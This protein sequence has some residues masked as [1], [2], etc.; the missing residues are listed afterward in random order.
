MKILLVNKFHYLKGGSEKYYFELAEL[1]KEHGHIVAFFSMKND[2]NIKTGDKEYFVDE[3]DL[4]T[5][6]KFKALD[7][8]YSKANE[9]LMEK[10]LD[11]FKPD[12]VHIN[13]FQRQLSASIIKP[14]KKRNIPIVFTAHDLQ[15]V[16]PNSAMLRN[17]MICEECKNGNYKNCFKYKCTKNSSLKSL[18]SV[19]EAKYYIKHEI[20]EQFDYIISPS[21][22]VANKI[23]EEKPKV[24]N[25]KTLYNF[26][27][28]N[29]NEK[30]ELMDEGYALFSGRLSQ[31]KG[32]INLINAFSNVKKGNLYIAGDGPEK[33]QIEKII[34]DNKMQ[35]RIKL[36]G[37]LNTEDMQDTLRKC[38][39]LVL[40]SVWYENC[41]FSIIEA[42]A[43]GKP[44]VASKIGGIPELIEEYKTGYLYK[45]D[46]KNELTD[47]LNKMFETNK[48]EE[49]SNNAKEY[50]KNNFS[51][52]KYYNEL[53]RI[54]KEVLDRNE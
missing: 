21:N 45:Y 36:L 50:A 31:E 40:P 3:I 8:I 14:I 29:K 20:Y 24:K 2:K 42:L 33:K 6:S 49:L 26:I 37:Y 22:F 53:I 4:N 7:V 38:K 13:N 34:K 1:L 28:I 51:K 10:A 35:K 11:E 19:L 43:M 17:G 44:V 47:S 54:Y 52:E 5:G 32:I 46:D 9:K 15:A 23:K 12:I 48:Y 41:P 30:D 16:C 39:F 27:E 18:L 25:I